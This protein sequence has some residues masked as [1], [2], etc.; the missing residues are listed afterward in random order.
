MLIKYKK[1][2]GLTKM[3]EEILYAEKQTCFYDY[4]V[5]NYLPYLTLTHKI[6]LDAHLANGTLVRDHSVIF[7]C[8]DE[9]SS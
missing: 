1:W 7:D 4:F 8:N 9:K 6:N 5:P 3:D 2:S